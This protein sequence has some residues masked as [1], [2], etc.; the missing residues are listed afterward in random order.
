M[1]YVCLNRLKKRKAVKFHGYCSVDVTNI[2]E[3]VTA[4]GHQIP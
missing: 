3:D 4:P 2:R 1:L